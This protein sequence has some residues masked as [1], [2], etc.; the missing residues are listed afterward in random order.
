MGKA[1][2][3]PDDRS[4]HLLHVQLRSANVLIILDLSPFDGD[5]CLET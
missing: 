4:L 5:L 3:F 2:L 1:R